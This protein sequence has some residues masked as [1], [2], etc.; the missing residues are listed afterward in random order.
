LNSPSS[1][2]FGEL[3][4]PQSFGPITKSAWVSPNR[5]VY[6]HS[7]TIWSQVRNHHMESSTLGF[8]KLTQTSEKPM[9]ESMFTY[10]GWQRPFL[11]LPRIQLRLMPSSV[12]RNG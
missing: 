2:R 1:Q 9:S 5:R 4:T 8:H 6:K 12:Y 3:A 11:K 7:H 10:R